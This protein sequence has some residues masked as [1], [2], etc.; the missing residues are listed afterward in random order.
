VSSESF[1]LVNE[2]SPDYLGKPERPSYTGPIVRPAAQFEAEAKPIEPTCKRRSSHHYLAKVQELHQ[3]GDVAF[4]PLFYFP[5]LTKSQ[6][7]SPDS[8]QTV[9]VEQDLA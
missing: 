2:V 1:Q 4:P 9:H 3:L 5:V 8:C 6:S 7:A